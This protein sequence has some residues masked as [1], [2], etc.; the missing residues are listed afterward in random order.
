MHRFD[1]EIE[2]KIPIPVGAIEDRALVQSMAAHDY[3]GR[4]L[5]YDE[6]IENKVKSLTADEIVAALRRTIDPAQLT[7]VKAGDF[8][9][10]AATK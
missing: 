8:K 6:Q 7:I 10:A 5:A 1:I 4:T 2:R 9:K 3:D